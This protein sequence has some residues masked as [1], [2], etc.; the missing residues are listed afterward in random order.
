VVDQDLPLALFPAHA[1]FG[2]TKK[3]KGLESFL[4]CMMSG[5]KV[6]ERI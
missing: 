1:D 2:C 3:A 6:V 5:G 4:M